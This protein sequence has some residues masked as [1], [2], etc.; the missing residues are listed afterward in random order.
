MH[1]SI[2]YCIRHNS[3]DE[4]R[5]VGRLPTHQYFRLDRFAAP[6]S[7][8]ILYTVNANPNLI[9]LQISI[10]NHPLSTDP[11]EQRARD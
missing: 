4:C 10:F 3:C 2:L 5:E 8:P 9:N 7:T 11:L 6:V 1:P